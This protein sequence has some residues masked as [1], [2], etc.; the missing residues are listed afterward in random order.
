MKVL[1]SSLAAALVA[2]VALPA[3]AVVT[4]TWSVETYQQFD[5]GDA[6]NAFITST[7]ELRPGWETKR[8]GLEG[9]AVWSALRLAD[10]SLLLGSDVGG[11]IYRVTDTGPKKLVSLDGAIAVVS[12]AQTSDGAVWAGAMP[13]NKLWKVDVGA[14]RASAGPQLKDTETIWS[15]AAHGDTVYAGTGPNGRLFA[16]KGGSAKTGRQRPTT[17]GSPRSRSPTDGAVWMGTSE[18]A[19]VFRY[20]PRDG[21]SRAMADFAGNEVTAIAPYRDGVVVAANDLAETP[22][23]TGKTA[24]QLE[25][26]EKPTAA[27]GQAMK[28][29]DAGSKPGADK[30]PPAVAD[31]GR[32]GAKKGKGALFRVGNDGRL[33]Q[34]H[35]LTA[36]YFTSVAV[37]PDG[38]IYA[39]AADKGRIYMVDSDGA[40]ATAFD[41]D[42]RA[43]SQLWF[44]RNLLSFTTDDAAAL[45]RT[46]GRASAARYV[47][48]VLDAQGGLA[49][50]QADVVDLG[51]GQAR[52]PQWQHREARHRLERMG[53]APADREARRRQRGRQDREPARALLAVPRRARRR[54]RARSPRL[55]VLRAAKQPPRWFRTSRSSSR[56]KRR[57]R[58]SR[59]R[60]A[61]RAARCCA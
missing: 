37:S 17:S 36:T 38:A 34:L 26:A 47:S 42:E 49:L 19:L 18:R 10:G 24:T 41:V 50:R 12:L 22:L 39:G 56:R 53:G 9:D 59:I 23:P 14:G 55:G 5:A 58:R 33:E 16:I 20:D 13:G 54:C 46:V 40:V 1:S 61:S 4:A 48:D 51:Q 2:L 32:K 11:A 30:D 45:Y 3:D 29:P 15:L 43:V 6:T 44:D 57:C 7:G 31:L 52:D 21:K 60:P 28:A 27:K 25:S 35:A 8:T